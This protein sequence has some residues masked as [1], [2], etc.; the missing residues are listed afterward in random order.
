MSDYQEV[1]RNIIR[2]VYNQ[3]LPRYTFIVHYPDCSFSETYHARNWED[4]LNQ[5][6]SAHPNANLEYWGVVA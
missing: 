5:A 2:G 1:I 6:D 4:A 3:V